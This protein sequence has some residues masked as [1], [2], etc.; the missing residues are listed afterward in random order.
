MIQFQSWLSTVVTEPVTWLKTLF[1]AAPVHSLLVVWCLMKC[2]HNKSNFV[3]FFFLCT[4]AGQDSRDRFSGAL[5]A[6][7]RRNGSG[8][9]AVQADR[10]RPRT[11]ENVLA[12]SKDTTT[13]VSHLKIAFKIFFYC[14]WESFLLKQWIIRSFLKPAKLRES[15]KTNLVNKT[16]KFFKKS[17][18]LQRSSHFFSWFHREPLEQSCPKQWPFL[19]RSKDSA[20]SW[21][22]H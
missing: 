3:L 12:S 16:R 21:P 1:V 4:A 19:N 17:H 20:C 14:S 15:R 2:R 6:Y 5:E 22:D 11:S 13:P 8:S 10:S 9:G 18:C 7:A